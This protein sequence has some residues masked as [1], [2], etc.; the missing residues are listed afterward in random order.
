[1]T[2]R[3][4]L[5][6]A[7]LFC[8]LHIANAQ[9][10]PCGYTGKSPWLDWYQSHKHELTT[11]RGG[12]TVWLYVPITVHI[13]TSAQQS[14]YNSTNDMLTCLNA[15][16]TMNKQF[17]PARIR[18]YFVEGDAF[19]FH[20]NPEW[21]DHDWVKGAELITE[22]EIPGRLNAYLVSG[23]GGACG[24]SWL[25][26]IVLS[27]GCSALGNTTWAHEAGHH[28]SLP[29]TFL[30][31]EG[32]KRD[33]TKPAPKTIDGRLVE[34][35]ERDNCTVA[36]DGFC[37]T[38]ADYISD[39]WPCSI[40]GKSHTLLTDPQGTPFRAD[41]SFYMSYAYD[42]CSS[43]FSNE[44]IEAMRANLLSE[45]SSYLQVNAPPRESADNI[46]SLSSPVD[47]QMVQ[48]N[49]VTFQWE[50]VPNARY[51]MVEV[52]I[53]SNFGAILW[54]K[55]VSKE[56]IL[57]V[58]RPMFINRLHYWRVR[59]FNEWDVCQSTKNLQT[60]VFMTQNLTATN[61]LERSLYFELSPNPAIIGQPSWFTLN[62]EESM[63]AR[64][65]LTDATG[66]IC[67]NQL[68]EISPGE[69]KL[70]VPTNTLSSGFYF[71]NLQNKKGSIQKRL[72]VTE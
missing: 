57:A 3:N 18:F 8:G 67:Y 37:D 2:T 58:S 60:G 30:G 52:S 42:N 64:L 15:V 1:M 39:R 11:N 56:T 46:V 63:Q 32:E 43:R 35:V 49:N 38:P 10:Q 69:N 70:E 28:F 29:H 12:D 20:Y 31:W 16:C 14:T 41:A 51:Y 68:I 48:F 24:Y 7:S 54:S 33:W 71:V 47:T 23:A 13:V 4:L 19:R 40:E 26:A 50:P 72:V 53:F 66:R 36:G 27:R 21:N 22:N 5:F 34:H 61:D 59:A 55:T 44:Q 45:H 25:D 65:T 9:T 62:T 17:E 6:I